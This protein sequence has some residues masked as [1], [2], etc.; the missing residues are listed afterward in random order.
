MKLIKQ[1][2]QK[3]MLQNDMFHIVVGDK[4]YPTYSLVPLHSSDMQMNSLFSHSSHLNQ[5]KKQ[6]YM[7]SNKPSKTRRNLQK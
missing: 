2:I 3:I 5:F 6:K 7:S 1:W 4:S